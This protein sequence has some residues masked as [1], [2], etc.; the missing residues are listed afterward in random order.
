MIRHTG[1]RDDMAAMLYQNR[2]YDRQTWKILGQALQ[3]QLE[4]E[5]VIVRPKYFQKQSTSNKVGTNVGLTAIRD[6][7]AVV[8]AL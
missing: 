1:V 2:R 5:I 7:F 8:L 3:F 4:R 6:S